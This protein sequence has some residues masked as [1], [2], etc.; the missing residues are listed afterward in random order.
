M[1]MLLMTEGLPET[2]MAGTFNAYGGV[3]LAMTVAGVLTAAISLTKAMSWLRDE[4]HGRRH[5]KAV[6]D[7]HTIK[8]RLLAAWV[9]LPPMWLYVEAIF[10]YRHFGKAACFASFEHAQSLVMHGWIVFVAV[11]FL[12]CFG[13]E[14]FVNE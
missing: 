10:F 2:C 13:R 5:G 8:T 3:A 9:L 6:P 4:A 11:L 12:L 7:R 14:I 1:T